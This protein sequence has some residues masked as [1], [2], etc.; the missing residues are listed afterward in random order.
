MVYSYSYYLAMLVIVPF[1]W[2]RASCDSYQLD[3]ACGLQYTMQVYLCSLLL[4]GVEP[5]VSGHYRPPELVVDST[6]FAAL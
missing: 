4:N 1:D 5:C 6:C 2:M 3:C